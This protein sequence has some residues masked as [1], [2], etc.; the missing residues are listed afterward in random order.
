MKTTPPRDSAEQLVAAAERAALGATSPAIAEAHAAVEALRADALAAISPPGLRPA[1][2]AVLL[3]WQIES[4]RFPAFEA[5]GPRLAALHADAI[6]GYPEFAELLRGARGRRLVAAHALAANLGRPD[7]AGEAVAAFLETIAAQIA[8][9][10]DHP[11]HGP[12]VILVETAPALISRL[13]VVAARHQAHAAAEAEAERARRAAEQATADR[14]AKAAEAKR[15]AE[16][17][18]AE[19]GAARDR[20]RGLVDFYREH[21]RYTFTIAGEQLTGTEAAAA[22]AEGAEF[23]PYYNG[24][25]TGTLARRTGAA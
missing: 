14:A 7:A 1:E 18:R 19:D 24:Q 23:P 21:A 9:R 3:E 4:A 25:V 8:Q 10:P 17:L 11:L 20:R 16:R 6:D 15:R 22:L 13:D 12:A 2:A 5:A